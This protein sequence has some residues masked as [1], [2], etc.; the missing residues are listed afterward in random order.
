MILR[1]NRPALLSSPDLRGLLTRDPDRLKFVFVI[2]RNVDDLTSIARSLFKGISAYHVSLLNAQETDRLVNLSQQNSTLRWSRDALSRVRE[3]TNGHPFLYPELCSHV[4]EQAY[5]K[6]PKRPP[7][8]ALQDIDTAIPDALEASR[9]TLEWL[10]DG[11]PPAARVV[12]SALAAAGPNPI[13]QEDLEHLLRESG[14]RVV[15]RGPKM[16]LNS[17]RIGT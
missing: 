5:D 10:W 9:N 3:L 16:P 15:I 17:C 4:W 7:A 8:I 6:E 11:L 1:L 12:A 14:V 13:S 2:C